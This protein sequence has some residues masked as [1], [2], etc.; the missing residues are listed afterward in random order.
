[1]YFYTKVHLSSIGCSKAVRHSLETRRTLSSSLKNQLCCV[2]ISVPRDPNFPDWILV[3]GVGRKCLT[4]EVCD[5]T[6]V[7]ARRREIKC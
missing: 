1:M 6:K 5:K 4:E 3:S 2:I 7:F